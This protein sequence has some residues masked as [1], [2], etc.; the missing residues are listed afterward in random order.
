[1]WSGWAL[2]IASRGLSG[3]SEDFNKIEELRTFIDTDPLLKQKHELLLKT[4][5]RRPEKSNLIK[6]FQDLVDEA[7]RRYGETPYIPDRFDPTL[8][9]IVSETLAEE[10]LRTRQ[11]QG[12]IYKLRHQVRSNQGV[13]KKELE[14]LLH[15]YLLKDGKIQKS[16]SVLIPAGSDVLDFQGEE[17]MNYFAN[18]EVFSSAV[19]VV[20]TGG[21]HIKLLNTEPSWTITEIDIF[22]FKPEKVF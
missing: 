4:L 17:E 21:A 18:F 22:E 3:V 11:K 15:T 20:A 13:L 14:K 7:A 16:S 6:L 2:R 1:M 8:R 19:I 12:S 9:R 5:S 10:F